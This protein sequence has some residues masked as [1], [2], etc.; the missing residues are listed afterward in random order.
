MGRGG[1]LGEDSGPRVLSFRPGP[2]QP[3]AGRKGRAQR[4]EGQPPN[5]LG[6]GSEK[7]PHGR[8]PSPPPLPL[9]SS[10]PPSA[11]RLGLPCS[12]RCVLPEAALVAA[13]PCPSRARSP[14]PPRGPGALQRPATPRSMPM[15]KTVDHRPD[16]ETRKDQ[17]RKI[18]EAMGAV[19]P[20]EPTLVEQ[21]LPPRCLLPLL[22][23]ASLPV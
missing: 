2:L 18:Q 20:P 16:Q 9:F 22:H 5:G 8:A 13:S 1:S 7:L 4:V 12:L 23:P 6:A 10:L 3:A 17:M 15:I 14:P 19:N 21:P 11:P